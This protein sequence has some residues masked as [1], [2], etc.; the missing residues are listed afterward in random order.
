MKK[1]LK[2]AFT[3]PKKRA[4][5]LYVGGNYNFIFVSQGVVEQ[6]ES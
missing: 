2:I 4:F 1:T 3:I 6:G 5:R